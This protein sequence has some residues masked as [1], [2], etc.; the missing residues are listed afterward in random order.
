MVVMRNQGQRQRME[1]QRRDPYT[2][3]VN[4][5]RNCYACR[6]FGHM[7]QHYRNRGEENRIGEDTR[8]EYGPRWRGERINRQRNNLK[9]EENLE[10]LN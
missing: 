3:E 2:M 8:L 6:E 9:E 4:R 5:G 1:P 7:A 10:S